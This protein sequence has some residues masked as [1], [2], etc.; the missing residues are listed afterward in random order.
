MQNFSKYYLLKNYLM[1]L[2][3]LVL[4]L[5][6]LYCSDK[7]IHSICVYLHLNSMVTL[8]GLTNRPTVE[9]NVRI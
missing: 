5:S 8:L 3:D 4:Q 1:E 7:L 6:V 9:S 2:E